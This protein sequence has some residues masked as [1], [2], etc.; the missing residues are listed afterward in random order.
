MFD[1]DPCDSSIQTRSRYGQ[2]VVPYQD[3]CFCANSIKRFSAIGQT[4][5]HTHVHTL[6]QKLTPDIGK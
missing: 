6:K 2:N 1:L 3:W 4:D 5:R